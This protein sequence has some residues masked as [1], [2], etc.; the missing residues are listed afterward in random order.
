MPNGN[1]TGL[2]HI[3]VNKTVATH[4]SDPAEYF[5]SLGRTFLSPKRCSAGLYMSN[6][7]VASGP[8]CPAQQD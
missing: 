2:Y 8:A 1:S 6:S 5:T 7:G 4:T 3:K